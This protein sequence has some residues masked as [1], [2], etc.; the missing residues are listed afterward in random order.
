MSIADVAK[1]AGTKVIKQCHQ[2]IIIII[3]TRTKSTNSKNNK[4]NIN[5]N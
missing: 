1:L 3:S 4:Y 5:Y 2:E